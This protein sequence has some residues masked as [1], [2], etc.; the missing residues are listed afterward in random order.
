MIEQDKVIEADSL[1]SIWT[2]N[3]KLCSRCHGITVL[4]EQLWTDVSCFLFKWKL[5]ACI[6]SE[7]P[8]IDEKVSRGGNEIGIYFEVIN[9]VASIASHV[10]VCPWTACPIWTVNPCCRTSCC[11]TGQELKDFLVSTAIYLTNKEK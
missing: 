4:W 8:V 1:V 10:R 3:V 7:I 2:S 11:C 9:G 6:A 5:N